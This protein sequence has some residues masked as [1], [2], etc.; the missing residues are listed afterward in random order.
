MRVGDLEYEPCGHASHFTCIPPRAARRDVIYSWKDLTTERVWSQKMKSV[1]TVLT[2]IFV[3][4]KLTHVIDWSWWAVLAPEIAEV[5]FI[6]MAVSFIEYKK[7]SIRN[8][9]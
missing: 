8:L 4:L 9:K 5:T 6:L 7:A 1:F 3:V 2:L